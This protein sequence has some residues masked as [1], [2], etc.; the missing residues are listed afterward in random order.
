MANELELFDGPGDLA[1]YSPPLAP[2][3]TPG[4]S[5]NTDL[6]HE[7][8]HNYTGGGQLVFGQPLPPDVSYREVM[9]GYRELGSLFVSD[10]MRLGFN[11]TQSQQ[12]VTWFMNALASPPGREPKR[13]AFELYEH[14]SDPIF[15]AWANWAYDHGLSQR[16]VSAI[17]WW[18]SEA[19]RKLAQRAQPQV[20]TPPRMAPSSDPT[21]SLTD[22]QFEAVVKAN[23]IAKAK[24][25]V[26]LENLWGQSYLANLKMV[27]A[28]FQSLP[29]REQQALDVYSAGWI[30]A[31]NTKEVILGLFKQAIG[32]NSLPSGGGV[33]AEIDECERVMRTNRKAWLANNRLQARYRQLLVMRDGG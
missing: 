29:L 15:Q 33:Q 16:M 26:Y 30:R 13:H 3:P 7:S 4:F 24:T 31:L 23:E 11:V 9:Q 17:C 6:L 25:Y 1:P 28:Y 19:G 5:G 12:C 27:D 10:C 18:V 14:T 2:A 8:T 22:A 32:S 21:D 20:G